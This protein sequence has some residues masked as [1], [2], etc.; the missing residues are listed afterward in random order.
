MT[1]APQVRAAESGERLRVASILAAAF[2]ED[3][4]MAWMLGERV[5][6]SE[7][8]RRLLGSGLE[9]LTRGGALEITTDG[10]A[11]AV[12][13]GPRAASVA[14][15]AGGFQGIRA[16]LELVRATGLRRL[17]RPLRLFAATEK[18]HPDEPHWYLASLGTLPERQGTGAGSALLRARLAEVDREGVAA[19]LE[20]SNEANLP[21][22]QRFG[23]EVTKELRVDDAP[24][25]W[26]MLRP[27]RGGGAP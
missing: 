4:L 19:Y 22:Y 23:F 7:C 24:P 21:L 9:V 3:P 6:R 11:A 25:V 18:E 15:N 5:H 12:W 8:R 27:A 20:S 2:E 13:S 14:S 1:A 10:S 26:P 17:R 16:F